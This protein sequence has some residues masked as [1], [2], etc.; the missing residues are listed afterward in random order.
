[1]LKNVVNIPFYTFKNGYSTIID[2][3]HDY[4]RSNGIVIQMNTTCIDLYKNNNKYKCT[5]KRNNT[6]DY[7]EAENVIFAIPKHALCEIKY[8]EKIKKPLLNTVFSKELMRIYLEFPVIDKVPWF[9]KLLSGIMTTKTILRQLV[10]IYPEHGILMIYVAGDTATSL[11]YLDKGDKLKSELMYNLRRMFSDATIPDP[12]K[13]Y[14]AYWPEATH[15][16][17]PGVNSEIIG[18]QIIHPFKEEKVF[19]VGESYSLVQQWSE[20]ALESVDNFI[21]LMKETSV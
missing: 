17:K 19:I 5:I 6:D 15:M 21:N 18:K 7:I 1:M 3:L 2:K 14:K 9:G 4:L 11:N 8:L 20:G 10:P 16:W 12:T 13:I